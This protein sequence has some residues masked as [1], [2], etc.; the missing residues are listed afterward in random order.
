MSHWRFTR[1]T[2]R[3]AAR[4]RSA[5]EAWDLAQAYATTENRQV[6]SLWYEPSAWAW[7]WLGN[8]GE[9]GELIDVLEAHEWRNKHANR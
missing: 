8:D 4:N 6:A 1:Y 5:R 2:A 9:P 3:P 7:L